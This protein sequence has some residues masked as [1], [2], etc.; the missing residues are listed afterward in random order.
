MGPSQASPLVAPPRRRARGL[1]PAGP[2]KIL[3]FRRPVQRPA[4]WRAGVVA[5]IAAAAGVSGVALVAGLIGD[6]TDSTVLAGS[7]V[8]GTPA[9][10]A[11]IAAGIAVAYLLGV[12][13]RHPHFGFGVVLL[14]LFGE[15]AY[16]CAGLL[17]LPGSAG[18]AILGGRLVGS[19]AAAV[20][21]W[22]RRPRRI[23]P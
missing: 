2:A 1:R 10:A 6:G 22:R 16:L 3:P 4:A 9:L 17:A 19:A 15:G 21:L 5:G 23:R 18:A 7:V 13:E 20:V 14:L 8:P 12:A 11:F